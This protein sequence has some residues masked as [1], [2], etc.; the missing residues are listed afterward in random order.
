MQLLK[1]TTTPMK[2]ELEVEPPRLEYQQDVTPSADITTTPSELRIRSQNAQ[3]QIDTYEARKS[4]GF[5]N[6][7]DSAVQYAEKAREHLTNLIGQFVQTGKALGQIQNGTDIGDVVRQKQLEQPTLYTAALPS[8]GAELSCKPSELDISYQPGE[9]GVNWRIRDTS[10]IFQPG[11]IQMRIIEYP[12]ID[13]EYL[14]KPMYVPP[15]A[16]PDLKGKTEI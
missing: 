8:T 16:S 3:I 6:L 1:I 15:S 13:I 14:G 4:L 7:K 2:Y 12:D 5:L 9:V 11:S 10:F